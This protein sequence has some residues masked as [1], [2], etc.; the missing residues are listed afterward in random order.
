MREVVLAERL[1]ATGRRASASRRR[2]C[3]QRFDVP[4]RHQRLRAIVVFD[5]RA[6]PACAGQ[7]RQQAVVDEHEVDGNRQQPLASCRPARVHRGRRSGRGR[8]CDPALRGKPSAS[9]RSRSRFALTSTCDTSRAN[10]FASRCTCAHRRRARSR[11]CRCRPAA[12]PRPPA[13]MPSVMA[14][15]ATTACPLLAGFLTCRIRRRFFATWRCGQRV[16]RLVL[17]RVLAFLEDET[18]RRADELEALAEEV[19]EIAAVACPTA[20]AGAC[21]AR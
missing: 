6:L 10:R 2:R 9:N 21:R 16:L 15:R 7:R 5:A 11:P 3:A 4:Q 18:D 1:H 20:C 12:S 8:A 13:R 19:F 14:S 17:V